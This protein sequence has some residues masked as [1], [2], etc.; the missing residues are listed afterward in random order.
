S[1]IR[2]W[3]DFY[4]QSPGTQ[5]QHETAKATVEDTRGKLEAKAEHFQS[6]SDY[7]SQ[8]S[9]HFRHYNP[10]S[11]P[12][13][14]NHYEV[15]AFYLGLTL[16]PLSGKPGHLWLSADGYRKVAKTEPVEGGAP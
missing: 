3:A 5:V 7:D 6:G 16:N 1:G 10:E 13:P 11:E 2:L 12:D 15:D 4:A 9:I 14:E 8:L